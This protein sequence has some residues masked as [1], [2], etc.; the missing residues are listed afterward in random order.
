MTD[1]PIG[2]TVRNWDLPGDG[3]RLPAR[4]DLDRAADAVWDD[5]GVIGIDSRGEFPSEIVMEGGPNIVVHSREERDAI[6]ELMAQNARLSAGG[7]P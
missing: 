5:V 4:S 7:R 1:Q 3:A 2:T 6:R